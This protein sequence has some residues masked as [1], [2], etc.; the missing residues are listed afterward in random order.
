MA[1]LLPFEEFRECDIPRG[2]PLR[3][4]YHGLLGRLYRHRLD[5]AVA[6]AGS[7]RRILEAGYGSGT[8]FLELGCR[9]GEVHG[10]DLHQ[11]GPQIAQVFGRHGMNVR[12]TRGNILEL[13]YADRSF[14]TVLAVS[15]LEHLR[16]ED[17]GPAMQEIRRV[18]RPQGALVVGAPG[19]NL[20]MSAAFRLM[21][22]SIGDYHL[23]SPHAIR[24]AAASLFV[25]DKVITRPFGAPA[26]LTTYQWF[27]GFKS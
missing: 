19:V 17:Q 18:L 14:D 22:F 7:G 5:V 4:Y 8:T 16:P 24:S 20:L 12:L 3:W 15:I 10:V 27:R 2:D 13:P 11:Y 21:G 9:F 25:I 26:A 6:L 1:Q 23:S